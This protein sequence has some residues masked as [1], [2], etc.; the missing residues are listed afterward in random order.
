M[1]RQPSPEALH[2]LFLP[3]LTFTR[4]TGI[5][6]SP[7]AAAFAPGPIAPFVGQLPGG[8][9][10]GE[11][12][13]FFEGRIMPVDTGDDAPFPPGGTEM[14]PAAAGAQP[15]GLVGDGTARV[16]HQRQPGSSAGYRQLI[17]A[18]HL[19]GGQQL[20][21]FGTVSRHRLSSGY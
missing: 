2:A 10:D 4:A 17:C 14:V 21:P 6:R 18:R 8:G 12:T 5:T 16:L 20:E 3:D 13:V 9:P 11:T 1:V 15:I 7:A 19:G